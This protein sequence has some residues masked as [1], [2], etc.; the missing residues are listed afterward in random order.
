MPDELIRRLRHLD[1]C[2]VSDALDRLGITRGVVLGVRP[3]SVRRRIAGRSVTVLL[4]LLTPQLQAELAGRGEKPR[5]LCTAAVDASGPDDVIVIANGGRQ[6]VAGWGGTLS[7]GAQVRGIEGVV[8]DGACRDADE[9]IDLDFAVYG[10]V[11]VPLTA[12]GRIVE[13]AWN[14]P[15]QFAGLTVTPGDLV[16]ADSSGV[17]FLGAARAEEIVTAAEDIA[18][19]E[20]AMADAVR[21]NRPMSEVMGA[22]YERLLERA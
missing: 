4:E 15:I 17:V 3:L 20:R 13:V 10:S 9:A 14:V 2:A 19:R 12:R 22:T 16:L 5:H 8:I 6:N 1:T 11:A 7:L 21:A 18:A